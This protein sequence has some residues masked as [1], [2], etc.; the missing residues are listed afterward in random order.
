[1]NEKPTRWDYITTAIIAVLSACW[2][3]YDYKTGT[4]KIPFEPLIAFATGAFAIWG[5]SRWRKS[6]A[7][8][9]PTSTQMAEKIYNIGEVRDVKFGTN[10][11]ESE[12]VVAGSKIRAKNVDIGNKTIAQQTN[13]KTQIIQYPDGKEIPRYLTNPPFQAEY[14]IGREKDLQAIEDEYQQ[15]NRPLVL[16]NGEGGIGKTTLAA[17][18]WYAHETRYKHLAWLFTDGGIGAA[19]LTL[20]PKLQVAFDAN[21]DEKTQLSRMAEAM[22]NMDKPW[23]LVLDNA[24][25]VAD[26]NRH[27]AILHQLADCHILITSR[28]RRSDMATYEV[29][30]LDQ[31]EAMRLFRHY[32]PQL[33]DA[34]LP[35]LH[36]ILLAVGYNTLVTELLAKNLAVFN[37]YSVQYSLED[38]LKELQVKGLLALK[39]KTVKVLYGSDSLRTEAP[40][41]IIAAMYDLA[42]LDDSERYL[43]SNLAVLPAENISY[44]LLSP[45]LGVANGD[46]DDALSSL[47]EKGWLEYREAD[48][49]FKISPV[50]QEVT[51]HKNADR[52]LNDC[53]T[54]METLTAILGD[55]DRTHR[56]KHAFASTCARL[57]EAVVYA[58]PTPDV[59]LSYLCQNI[60]NFYQDTGNLPQMMA[61]Y[62][63]MLGIQTDLC[64]I[65]SE[66]THFK[67]GLAISY[68]K[69]GSTQTALGNLPQAL[70][71]FEDETK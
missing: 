45:L 8:S 31:D 61:A 23:L 44:T 42:Q 46:L 48:N 1:M 9:S 60:G 47:E 64:Q 24:N 50:I 3:V 69:L 37:K 12:N 14:F 6:K 39:N 18:Y 41:D 58:M 33:A 54:L 43:L 22:N 17:K 53:R 57:G 56:D 51:R 66:N 65:E 13:I 28:T 67:N 11:K 25:D 32:Y 62:Q 71:F 29:K 59:N 20:A 40:K 55:A 19:L 68:E 30:P 34:E 4:G 15:H 52:L 35:L 27:Y 36:D 49:S 16:V 2:A 63:K 7:D 10:I 21:D 38:L 70:T 5:Y 26:L